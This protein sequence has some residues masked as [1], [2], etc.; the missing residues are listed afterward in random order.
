MELVCYV[1]MGFFPA[2]VIL[3]MVSHCWE[4]HGLSAR[5]KSQWGWFVSGGLAWS[6][7]CD[8]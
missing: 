7:L 1:I 4:A 3:S 8:G 5:D 6:K 2:L